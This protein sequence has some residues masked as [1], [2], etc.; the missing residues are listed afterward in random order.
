MGFIGA[1]HFHGALMIGG[2]IFFLIIILDNLKKS[3]KL[4]QNKRI[5][6][7][8]FIIIISI[9]IFFVFY[10][11][12][13]IYIPYIGNFE[14]ITDTGWLK[15]NIL[16][17]MRGDATYPE[18]TKIKTPIDL[19]YKGLLRSFYFLISPFPWDI[20]KTIHFFGVFDGLLY[21]ILIYLILKNLKVIWRDPALRIIL[22]IIASY[23]FIFGIGTSNFGASLRHRT[24][25]V[26][27]L[28]ILAAPLITNFTFSYKKK[29]RK[30]IN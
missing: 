15:D 27:E 23:I 25:F 9:V 11:T 20:T 18:W 7:Q 5:N 2:F 26:I 8:A 22:I 24:K 21:L 12:N 4:I 1:I 3:L 14:Q 28:I 16:Q 30:Y 17:R 13:N 6:L 10:F 19:I 29:L